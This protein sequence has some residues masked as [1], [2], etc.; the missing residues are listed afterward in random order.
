MIPKN[1]A[2]AYEVRWCATTTAATNTVGTITGMARR[3]YRATASAA[4]TASGMANDSYEYW[5]SK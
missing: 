2:S 4:I 5:L 3:R 1:P